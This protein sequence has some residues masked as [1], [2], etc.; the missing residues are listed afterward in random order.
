VNLQR[1]LPGPL[2]RQ[3]TRAGFFI[4]GFGLA[5]WAPLVPFAQERLQV[6]DAA[7]G[8][9]LLC[10]GAGSV[11]T[12]PLSGA[13]AARIGCRRAVSAASLCACLA[14]PLLTS[15][16][17][18]PALAA[19]LLLFGAGIGALDV[20]MN[21]Q[22]IIV[23]KAAGRALMSGFHGLFSIGGIAG[24]GGVSGLLWAGASPLGAALAVDAVILGLLLAF[25]RHLL[26]YGS[27]EQGPSPLFVLPRGV[28]L[29]IGGLCFI[30][31]MTEGSILDWSAIFLATARA[32]EPSR[33]GLGY[34]VFA[35]A[36]TIGRLSGDRIVRMVGGGTILAGGGLLAA[37]GLAVAVL[38]P[39]WI[40]ALAGFWMVGLGASNIVPVLYSALGRQRIMPP[41]L[42]VAAV[43][44]IGYLGILA[45]PALIGFT[46]HLT[47]LPAAFLCVGAL[48]LLVA[49]SARLTRP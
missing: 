20:V 11:G 32:V 26:P 40:A 6:N 16:G 18:G 47:S 15:V 9:L 7:L 21:V 3:A 2:E 29:A 41:N 35:L 33:S 30:T 49:A 45:G 37:S 31:F 42:A 34:A 12:M 48:M 24:A 13:L 28:V 4:A 46:A 39:S 10:L 8:L 14:L 19:A 43:T 5:A 1:P 36:M 44:T 38:I 25:G 27:E 23:E 22:A 17:S